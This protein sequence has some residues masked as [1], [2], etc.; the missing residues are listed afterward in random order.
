M[1]DPDNKAAFVAESLALVTRLYPVPWTADTARIIEESATPILDSDAYSDLEGFHYRI[2]ATGD[3]LTVTWRS[4]GMAD[5]DLEDVYDA[6]LAG[7]R[8]SI[9]EPTEMLDPSEPGVPEYAGSALW[10]AGPVA[11]TLGSRP[12]DEWISPGSVVVGVAQHHSLNHLPEHGTAGDD[13]PAATSGAENPDGELTTELIALVAK[14]CAQPW[15]SEINRMVIDSAGPHVSARDLVITTRSRNRPLGV[16]WMSARMEHGHACE[17]ARALI[18]RL[19]R[20]VGLDFDEHPFDP[21]TP[22]TFAVNNPHS[23]V[24]V[25]AVPAFSEIQMEPDTRAVSDSSCV[26]LS[27]SPSRGSTSPATGSTP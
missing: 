27:V 1:T 26:V 14:L 24:M 19:T 25:S 16:R 5:P 12:E 3:P 10:T 6:I 17:V 21:E 7:L 23:F 4:P 13:G 20:D 15:S 8:I 11:I 22:T 2:T 9:G 18:D